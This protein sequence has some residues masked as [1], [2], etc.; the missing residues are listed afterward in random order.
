[1]K[2][3]TALAAIGMAVPAT[4]FASCDFSPLDH[5]LREADV[6]YVG[7]VVTATLVKPLGSSGQS[8][9]VDIKLEVSPQITFKGDPRRIKGIETW[10]GYAPPVPKRWTKFA[11]IVPVE[12][13]DTLLIVGKNDDMV[14][15]D[16]CSA[17]RRWELDVESAVNKVLGPTPRLFTDPEA[18]PRKPEAG[19]PPPPKYSA[20]TKSGMR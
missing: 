7:T 16:L 12:P 9:R 20:G 18:R 11:E 15:V 4:A 13:G 19:N 2:I 5:E 1:M 14:A 6:V 17:S 8:R 3:V 10:N